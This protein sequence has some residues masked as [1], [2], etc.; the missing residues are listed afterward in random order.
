M[1]GDGFE[2]ISRSALGNAVLIPTCAV[3]NREVQI[4][5]GRSKN[6]FISVD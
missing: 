2:T 5:S 1:P 3:A 6:D 4:N